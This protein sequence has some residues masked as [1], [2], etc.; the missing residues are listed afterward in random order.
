MRAVEG[1]GDHQ[2]QYR[3]AEKLKAFIGW[4]AAM[5]VGIRTVGKRLFEK[6]GRKLD[7]QT[8]EETVC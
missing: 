2:P 8:G 5:F 3:V 7:A 4:Q 1:L 6:P